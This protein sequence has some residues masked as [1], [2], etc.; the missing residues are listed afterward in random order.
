MGVLRDLKTVRSKFGPIAIWKIVECGV[1]MSKFSM[2]I[3]FL[4]F[5]L[6]ACCSKQA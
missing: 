1:R 5:C 3:L 4:P 6:D 2:R